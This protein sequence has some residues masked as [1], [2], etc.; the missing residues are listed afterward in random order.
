VLDAEQST[1]KPSDYS[2]YYPSNYRFCKPF[3]RL[4]FLETYKE[5]PDD[6]IQIN[7]PVRTRKSKKIKKESHHDDKD[8]FKVPSFKPS[9]NQGVVR[10]TRSKT[11]EPGIVDKVN[12]KLVNT[13]SVVEAE[14][15][16]LKPSG[17]Q[18]SVIN[19]LSNISDI[20]E[21]LSDGFD[22]DNDF[23]SLS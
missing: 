16:N 13:N 14:Q 7:H 17:N 21:D 8:E 19:S 4:D 9:E 22:N 15:S 10:Y 6:Y 5:M 2:E 3:I 23:S 11:K 12:S 1:L 18:P 20:V